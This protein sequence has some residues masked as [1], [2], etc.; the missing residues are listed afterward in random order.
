MVV[1]PHIVDK[2]LISPRYG[3]SKI[4]IGT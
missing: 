2:L 3:A 1:Y 4:P